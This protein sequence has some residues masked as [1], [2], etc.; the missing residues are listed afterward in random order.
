[1]EKIYTNRRELKTREC[2]EPNDPDDA[3]Y[4][5]QARGQAW[6]GHPNNIGYR[7][8]SEISLDAEFREFSDVSPQFFWMKRSM[9]TWSIWV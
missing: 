6:M 9:E 4:P 3:N 7:N 2:E 5:I 1:M 8:I